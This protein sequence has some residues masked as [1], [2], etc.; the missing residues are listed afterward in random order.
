M[1]T[2]KSMK[3]CSLALVA[4]FCTESAWSWPGT[5]FMP[6]PGR[7]R[8]TTSRPMPSA[9]VVTT[10]KY[11]SALPPTLPTFFRL[12]I[13]E[14]PVTTVRKTMGPIT[15]LTILMNRSPSGFICT[16]TDG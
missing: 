2:T 1:P 14:M 4:Y 6:A 5:M 9:K 10:S 3:P 8:L 7:T 15:I 13:E 16:A 12:P 11:S